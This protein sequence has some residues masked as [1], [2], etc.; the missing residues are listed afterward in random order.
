MPVNR[1]SVV[2]I[3]AAGEGKRMRSATPKVLH[4]VAGRSLVGHVIE[5]ASTLEPLY[6]VVVVGHGRELVIEHVNE[7]APW[8]IT[9]VQEEQRGTGH[10]VRVA[11]DELAVR[12]IDLDSGPVVIL[13][14]DTPLLTGSTLVTLMGDHASAAASATVLTAELDDP[15]G[16]GRVIRDA[17]GAVNRIVEHK[18][19]S[20][21]ELDV[22]EVNSG[23]YAFAADGLRLMLSR[24][25]TEN[26]QA[27]EYLTDVIGLLRA[28]DQ[29]VAAS[30]CA[31][32]AEI[33][34]VNDRHQLAQAAAIMR[35]RINAR[36]MRDGVA[37][38]DSATTWLDVDVEIEPDARIL[39]NSTLRGPTSVAAGA[40]VGPGTTLIS[41][42]V[43]A[44]ASVI[45]TWAELAVIGARAS[46]GPFTYLRPGTVLGDDSKAGAYVEIKNSTV[47]SGSKV[48]HLSY[49]GDAEIGTGSNIG[50]ATVFVNYD[51]VEKHR[52]VVGDHVRIGSDT[53]LVAPVTIG[54]GAYTAAGS[55]ITDDVPPGAMAVGRARQRN[56]LEWVLR[57]RPGTASAASA[58]TA[59]TSTTSA[60]A[61][62]AHE[63]QEDR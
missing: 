27:E 59:T 38:L 52:T 43:G 45:H 60:Q 30:K 56:I 11:L 23:M 3:L 13:T 33:L 37:I 26:A 24:V 49:V 16:Y 12:G 35:D 53:M 1:P 55:V 28:D 10:A 54:D 17:S 61:N 46:I 22:T 15:T 62:A 39:P 8:A 44:D 32:D 6:L 18:D 48:P 31:D 58:A 2:V 9:V 47:G 50:A 4:S 20:L 41:C 57:R 36:W 40:S 21:N 42:E 29:S 63:V 14:G 5:A 19:A 51:G 34:G 25:T 7:I